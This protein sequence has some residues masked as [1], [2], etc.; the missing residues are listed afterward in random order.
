M[1]NRIRAVMPCDLA[2]HGKVNVG[3]LGTEQ[4]KLVL[5]SR[6]GARTRDMKP[7]VGNGGDV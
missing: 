1:A 6:C 4:K 7:A 2:G 3:S 5:P